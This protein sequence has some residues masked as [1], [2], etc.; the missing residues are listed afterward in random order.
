MSAQSYEHHAR[1][2]PRYHFVT[3]GILVV[4]FI[5]MVYSAIR[6]F[7]IGAVI[8][9]ATALALISLFLH[10]RL[11]PV[12]V[13]DGLIRLEERMRLNLLLP[14]SMK[15]RVDEFSTDQLIALRFASDGELPD[16]AA[17]VLNDGIKDRDQVK[18]LIKEWRP[19]LARI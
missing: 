16:L 9:A 4:N 14:D 7:S 3:F 10:A 13:Q 5:W 11:F 2:V 19:D 18:K 8:T 12:G 15:S 1:F 6:G 17:K